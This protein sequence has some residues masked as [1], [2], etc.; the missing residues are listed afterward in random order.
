MTNT[1]LWNRRAVRL[2]LATLAL[3]L[4]FAPLGCK[5]KPKVRVQATEEEAPRMA[6]TVSMGD[7]RSA[8]QLTSG[9]YTIEQG[10]WRWT[11][12]QFAIVLRPP[13]GAA[14]KGAVLKMELA[15]PDPVIAQLR[16]VSVT[17]SVNGH[18][19]PPET[20]T[21]P[22]PYTYTR[23]VDA[24]LM[25]GESVKVEFLLDKAIP[26]VT[27]GDQRELGIVARSIGLE[28]K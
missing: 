26:P 6:S 11:A 21:R 23:D 4:V 15:V 3:I 1:F 28:P 12:R 8:L 19:L 2:A 13:F 9:F 7:P 22:G 16:T 20:Y 27:G 17:A 5:R 18:L 10:S 24:S 14:E 25:T